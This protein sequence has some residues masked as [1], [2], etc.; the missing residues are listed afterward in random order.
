MGK[1]ISDWLYRVSKGWAALG[2]TAVFVLFVATVLPAQAA[3]ANEESG[4]AGSP[5]T[6]FLYTAQD[7]YDMVQA[8]GPDG[9]RAYV[10]AR[11]TF[12]LV[13]P[14][15]YTVFLCTAISWLYGRAFQRGDLWQR[16]NLVPLLGALFDLL[17]NLSTSLVMLRYPAQMPV[18]ASLA[19]AFTLVKWI[20]VGGSLVL[21]AVGAVAGIWRWS[22]RGERSV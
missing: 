9:R 3:K 15:V 16:A 8:Y 11:F 18:V 12:D 2:A 10:R 22:R 4:G 21:L 7:L 19:P 1:R 6:S 13:W 17:E 14:L 5:D 20:L